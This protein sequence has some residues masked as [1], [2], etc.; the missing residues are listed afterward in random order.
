[1]KKIFLL[2]ITIIFLPNINAVHNE[3]HKFL[4]VEYHFCSFNEG[5]G[6][7]DLMSVVKKFNKFLDQHSDEQSYQAALLVAKYDMD[8]QYDYIWY[9]GWPSR[10]LKAQ[11]LDNWNENGQDIAAEF[12]TVSKC[13][14]ASGYQYVARDGGITASNTPSPVYYRWCNMKEG[15]SRS[16]VRETIDEWTAAVTK[17]GYKGTSRIFYP[18][19]GSRE[20]FEADTIFV[21]IPGSHMNDYDNWQLRRD[22]PEWWEKTGPKFNEQLQCGESVVQYDAISLTD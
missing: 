6:M 3:D 17:A 5:M 11:S 21:D 19:I 9:G 15:V 22:N 10:K 2:I 14:S 12:S 20:S 7:T 18:T 8:N 16:D 13:D 4:S 1:M